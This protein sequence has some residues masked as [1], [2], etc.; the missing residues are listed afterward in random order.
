MEKLRKEGKSGYRY[1]NFPLSNLNEFP[2]LFRRHPGLRGLNVTTPYKEQ[3]IPWLEELDPKAQNIGAVNT[4]LIS[5]ERG[6]I[7]MKGFN[8]DADGFLQSADFSAHRQA[9]ILGTGGAAKA[10]AFA[11]KEMGIAFLF[12]SRSKKS[13]DSLGYTDLTAEIVSNHTLI[14][15]ATPLGMFPSGET[16]PAIPYHFLSKDHFL[17]DLIYN[18]E[19]TF[20]LKEGTAAGTRV[21]NG[22]KMLEIQAELSYQIWKE[23]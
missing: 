12:V 23:L 9:L 1:V 19:M 17:Y 6:N 22:M 11:L 21:Q 8:T 16:S 4:I 13:E 20:F 15:N 18:P 7:H 2:Y 3:I 14:V 10:V 5:R